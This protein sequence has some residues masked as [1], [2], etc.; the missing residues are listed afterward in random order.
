MVPNRESVVDEGV[1]VP[2]LSVESGETPER[3]AG[4]L[5]NR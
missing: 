3:P 5:R 1:N 4:T 2:G